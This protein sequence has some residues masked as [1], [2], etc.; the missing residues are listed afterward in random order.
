MSRKVT[1]VISHSP[2]HSRSGR[3]SSVGWPLR[4]MSG[5]GRPPQSYAVDGRVDRQHAVDRRFIVAGQFGESPCR[6][7]GHR[8]GR[9]CRAGLLGWRVDDLAEFDQLRP[10][11]AR[12]PPPACAASASLQLRADCGSA[13]VIGSG[14]RPS[15]RVR[16]ADHLA[17]EQRADRVVDVALDRPKH[18][19]R[20]RSGTSRRRGPGL[21][22]A[23]I[24]IDDVGHRPEQSSSTS[25]G[26]GAAGLRV[27]AVDFGQQGR[28]HR[29]AGRR[30]DDLD[31]R[32]RPAGSALARRSR[33]SSAMT[34]LE[35]SRS[36]LGAASPD[37]SPISGRLRRK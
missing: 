36:S 15:P 30:L 1:Q 37:R 35:R 21:A 17:A 27:G 16:I 6:R 4:R 2:S 29:R 34:W 18:S 25:V 5:L 24:D 11:S 19:S 31:R 3:L 26:D 12:T 23:V 9:A 32:A 7:R 8:G 10:P 28:Q 13:M 33:R 20:S 14:S 22:V